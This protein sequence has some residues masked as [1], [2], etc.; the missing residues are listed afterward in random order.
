MALLAFGGSAMSTT[1]SYN[2]YTGI[3]YAYNTEYVW[4]EAKQKKVQRKRCIGHIDQETGE[5]VPNGAPGRP[6]KKIPLKS[7]ATPTVQV[8]PDASSE[9]LAELSANVQQLNNALSV[10]AGNLQNLGNDLAKV[11]SK[12]KSKLS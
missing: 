1:V 11:L 3:Y 12:D 10:L 8:T 5:V 9:Y 7:Q 6:R 2:K 4:D